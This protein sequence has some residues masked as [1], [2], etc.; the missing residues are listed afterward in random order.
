MI[1]IKVDK[2]LSRK[3]SLVGAAVKSLVLVQLK[4]TLS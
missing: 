2:R 1:E 4:V 3:R